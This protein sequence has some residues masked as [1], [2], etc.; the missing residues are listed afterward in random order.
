MDKKQDTEN[1]S[2][3]YLPEVEQKRKMCGELGS[4]QDESSHEYTTIGFTFYRLTVLW[5]GI[6]VS[7]N[8]IGNHLHVGHCDF[9]M[10][11]E[12]LKP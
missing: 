8:R 4:V 10:L 6:L 1:D 7:W 12:R 3:R 9:S 2:E 11:A 5:A